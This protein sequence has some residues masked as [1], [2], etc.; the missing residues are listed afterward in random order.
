MCGCRPPLDET[1]HPQTLRTSLDLLSQVQ[2]ALR[3]LGG[4]QPSISTPCLPAPAELDVAKENTCPRRWSHSASLCFP[5][6]FLSLC[7]F[8]AANTSSSVIPQVM[9]L[10]PVSLR[11]GINRKRMF[12]PHRLCPPFLL[13]LQTALVLDSGRPLY[14]TLDPTPSLLRA[15]VQSFSFFLFIT[16]SPSAQ[17]FLVSGHM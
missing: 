4:W 17:N 13:V 3:R 7:L 5:I 16:T 1:E 10:V 2:V 9:T 8:S 15:L 14:W 11:K 6:H 12:T